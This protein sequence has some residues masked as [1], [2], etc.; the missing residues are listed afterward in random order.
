MVM[1]GLKFRRLDLHIHTPASKCFKN[2]TIKPDDIIKKS[3]EMRLDAIAI[4]DHN[5]AE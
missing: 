2:K 5:S 3:L 4:T 1:K